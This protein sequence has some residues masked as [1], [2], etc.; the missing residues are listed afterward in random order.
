MIERFYQ[1]LGPV[2]NF[3]YSEWLFDDARRAAVS[4]LGSETQ[5]HVLE[6]GVGT[7]LTLPIYPQDWKVIGI[8][9]SE[10]MLKK[11]DLLIQEKQ[12]SNCSVKMMNAKK[13]EF[14]DNSFDGVLGNLFISATSEPELALAEMKRVCKPNG[15]LVLM[16]H[17]RSENAVLQKFEDFIDPMTEKLTGFK[18]ALNLQQLI[19]H[20]G[21]VLHEKRQVKPLGIWTAVAFINSK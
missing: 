17:F 5:K 9:L 13:L 19:Q 2:Y 12:L 8:D 18:A 3:L 6:I 14:P 4:L 20:N 15:K 11:A 1:K 21:L 10:S 7:G 16:N